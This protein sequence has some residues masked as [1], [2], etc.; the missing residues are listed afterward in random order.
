MLDGAESSY[1]S[2]TL[3]I[4]SLQHAA[5]NRVCHMMTVSCCIQVFLETEMIEAYKDMC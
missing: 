3:N 1:G 4:L 5:V 2:Y